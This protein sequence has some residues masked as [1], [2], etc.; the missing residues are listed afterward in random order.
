MGKEGYD[1]MIRTEESSGESVW[2]RLNQVAP[3]HQT[4]STSVHYKS[5]Q[6]EYPDYAARNKC[7]RPLFPKARRISKPNQEDER[8]G[9][10]RE[11]DDNIGD[12]VSECSPRVGHMR[13]R[14]NRSGRNTFRSCSEKDC[15]VIW[16]A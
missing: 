16:G 6:S 3:N 2:T 5:H 11:W 14:I 4:D 1:D 12:E 7:D 15:D 8:E 13:I 10:D 9:G